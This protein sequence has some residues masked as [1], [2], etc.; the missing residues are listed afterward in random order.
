MKINNCLD[1]KL[2]Y[3]KILENLTI[4]IWWKKTYGQSLINLYIYRKI[5]F[6]YISHI[7]SN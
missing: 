1:F 6:Y 4:K 2:I 5:I 7:Q 3:L